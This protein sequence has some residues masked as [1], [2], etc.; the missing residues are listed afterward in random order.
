[1]EGRDYMLPVDVKLE[2]PTAVQFQGI[3]LDML[4]SDKQTFGVVIVFDACRD[5][6]FLRRV[7]G[8]VAGTHALS[9]PGGAGNGCVTRWLRAPNCM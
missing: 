5:N 4:Y 8:E 1:M 3:P 6:P 2:T 7:K 9:P